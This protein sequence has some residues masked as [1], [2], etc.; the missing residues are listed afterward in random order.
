MDVVST[1]KKRGGLAKGGVRAEDAPLATNIDDK[2]NLMIK[3][4]THELPLIKTHGTIW[5][6]SP[7]ALCSHPSW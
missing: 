5:A 6:C 2:E 4:N 1:R 7:G 3:I